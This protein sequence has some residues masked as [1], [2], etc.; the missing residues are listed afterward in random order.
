M[1]Y[2][3]RQ[4]F[5]H[6]QVLDMTLQSIIIILCNCMTKAKYCSLLPY[7]YKFSRDI[8]FAVF[9]VNLLSTKFK[10]SKIYKTVVIHLKYKV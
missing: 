9:A 10:S 1:Y 3:A 2:D 6:E 5:D 7:T 4:M 8:N